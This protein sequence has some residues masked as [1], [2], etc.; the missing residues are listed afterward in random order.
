MCTTQSISEVA[1]QVN[2]T[3]ILEHRRRLFDVSK[4]F[5]FFV[6]ANDARSRFGSED[7]WQQMLE[8]IYFQFHKLDGRTEA[9]A[10]RVQHHPKF[11]GEDVGFGLFATSK[12]QKG[13]IM[14]S[15][16]ETGVNA[17]I[18]EAGGTLHFDLGDE[19]ALAPV[20]EDV[21]KDN[22]FKINHTSNRRKKNVKIEVGFREFESNNRTQIFVIKV[23]V[24]KDIKQGEELAFDYFGGEVSWLK[25]FT[26]T[27]NTRKKTVP[28]DNIKITSKS[29]TRTTKFAKDVFGKSVEPGRY[30]TGELVACWWCVG[31]ALV[32]CWW[33]VGGMLVVCWWCVGGVLVVG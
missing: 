7:L 28:T 30:V 15:T 11:A 8:L 19:T 13:E 33:H 18:V 16:L 17:R 22:V 25:E 29:R 4:I 6:R 14:Y 21:T 23:E 10:S 9:R 5:E 27:V 2:N 31:G 26:P 32:A 1:K 12:I 20:V 3:E 24:T